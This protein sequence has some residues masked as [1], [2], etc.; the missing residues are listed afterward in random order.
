MIEATLTGNSSNLLHNIEHTILFVD[1]ERI[2]PFLNLEWYSPCIDLG[3][4]IQVSRGEKVIYKCM[5]CE[6]SDTY[7]FIVHTT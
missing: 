2:L 5:I 3:H 4:T 6:T 1:P 7:I